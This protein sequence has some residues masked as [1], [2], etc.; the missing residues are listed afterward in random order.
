MSSLHTEEDETMWI[1]VKDRQKTLLVACTYRTSYCDLLNGETTKL[2]TSI[3]KASSLCKNIL[4]FGDFNCDLNEATPDKPTRKLTSCMTEMNLFQAIT[5]ATRI[6]SGKPKLIDHIWIEEQMKEDVENSGVC[7]GISDHAGIYAF[8]KGKSEEEEMITC[9]NYR[10]YE[11]EKLC[12]DFRTNLE[13]SEFQTYLRS[14]N[15]NKATE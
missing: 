12:E 10:N 1:R 2:E 14:K 8:I 11:K 3:V 9:R 7:T 13:N 4:L 5:G 15:V 6:E